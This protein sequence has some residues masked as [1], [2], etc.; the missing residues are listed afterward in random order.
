[1][2]EVVIETRDRAHLDITVGQL[3]SAGFE[4]EVQN[5]PGGNN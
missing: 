3:R 1:M 4:V 2:D 5:N